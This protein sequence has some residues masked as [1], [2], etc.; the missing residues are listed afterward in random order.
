MKYILE[1][2]TKDPFGKKDVK[3]DI[4]NARL[5]KEWKEI[6]LELLLPNSTVRKS[7]VYDLKFH[8]DLNKKIREKELPSGF[9]MGIDKN[10]FFIYTHRARSKS[11]DKASEITVKE[12]KFV[13]STG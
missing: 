6:A 10:G 13:D 9:S 3:E 11:H 7:V 5:P 12:I 1:R 8:T 4:K 2:I